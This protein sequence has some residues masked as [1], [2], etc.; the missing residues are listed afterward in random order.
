M[1]GFVGFTN[2]SADKKHK[3]GKRTKEPA[4]Y[5]IAKPH[6]SL[7]FKLIQIQQYAV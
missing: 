2:R 7:I 1:C 5:Y 4:Q 6:K 3:H